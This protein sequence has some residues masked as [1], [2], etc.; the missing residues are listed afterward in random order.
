MK[1]TFTLTV[2]TF[3]IFTFFAND[4]FAIP[5]FAQKI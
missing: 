5:A 4:V 3:I 1:N 2:L